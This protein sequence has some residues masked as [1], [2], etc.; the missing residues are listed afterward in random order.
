MGGG[1][2][3]PGARV[4][5]QCDHPLVTLARHD[6]TPGELTR[7]LAAERGNHPFL[8]FRN[9][10]AE[11]DL[12]ELEGDRIVIGRDAGND[13]VLPWDVEV[14]RVHAMLERL[15]G[16]WT[17]VDDDLSR[18]G[19]FVNGQRVRGR[20]RLNDNDILRV[21]ATE[22]VYRNP[23][24]EAGETVRGA[25]NAATA[26][27]TPS[28]QRVLVALCRP[29]LASDGPGATPPS[30]AELASSVGISTEAVRSHLKTLFKVF[31]IPDL[32]QNRK[33]AELA[34]RALAAGVVGP[35]DLSN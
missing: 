25:G 16:A 18:N 19:T 9:A 35:R 33:R 23:L 10:E 17:V 6:L 21:G 13:L 27:V 32:P 5:P 12:V 11:L 26:G 24:D 1:R 20:R 29:L 22:L 15:A 2:I 28:Q 14:S 4:S 3:A 8:A 34:R 31:E 7:V 30:N